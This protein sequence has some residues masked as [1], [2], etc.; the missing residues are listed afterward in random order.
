M[1][2]PALAV[3]TVG[4]VSGECLDDVLENDG[5]LLGWLK[6][7]ETLKKLE[8][9]VGHLPEAQALEFEK[10]ILRYPGLFGDMPSA[11]IG[12]NMTWMWVKPEK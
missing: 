4:V 3:I 9:L 8:G 7:S 1:L 11:L 10:L 6:N 5:V 2:S 12:S